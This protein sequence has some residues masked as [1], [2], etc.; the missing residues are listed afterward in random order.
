[1]FFC[2]GNRGLLPGISVWRLMLGISVWWLNP[3]LAKAQEADPYAESVTAIG[4]RYSC[5]TFWEIFKV[6]DWFI[7]KDCWIPTPSWRGT[8]KVP[9]SPE[10]HTSPTAYTGSFSA[11]TQMLAVKRICKL[12]IPEKTD[13]RDSES[14]HP[15]QINEQVTA[16]S[17]SQKNSFHIKR[18]IKPTQMKTNW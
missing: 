14:F 9:M 1:M 5:L 18:G 4:Q 11:A 16:C 10:R 6:L 7:G 15:Y 3:S 8:D 13:P 17:A 12:E 2:S